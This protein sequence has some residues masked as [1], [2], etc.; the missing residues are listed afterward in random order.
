PRPP[1]PALFPYTTLFRSGAVRG[2]LHLSRAGRPG[3]HR[4]PAAALPLTSA[5]D[6]PTARGAP[7]RALTEEESMNRPSRSTRAAVFGTAILALAACASTPPQGGTSSASASGAYTWWDPY[8][9][10]DANSAWAKR[11]DACGQEAGVT[12]Q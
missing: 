3:Q 9:Q 12:I 11:V 1:S 10:H 6:P 5:P 7:M 4:A 8:P 2:A